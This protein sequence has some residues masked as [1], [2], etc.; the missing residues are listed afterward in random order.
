MSKADAILVIDDVTDRREHTTGQLRA[1]G[2]HHVKAITR[3]R[4]LAELHEQMPGVVFL[5]LNGPLSEDSALLKAIRGEPQFD[6]TAVV[7]GLESFD[8]HDVARALTL[9]ADDCVCRP[10]SWPNLVARLRSQL[11][12][13]RYI[14]RIA[15]NEHDLR[16]VVQLTQALASSSDIRD[17]LFTVAGRIAEITQIDR[18][19]VVL[20]EEGSDVGYVVASSDDE[21]LRDRPIGLNSYPEIREVLTSR[22]PL[23]IEDIEQSELLAKVR[24]NL[25]LAFRS[26]T[27]VPILYQG[28]PLG[29]LFL[30]GKR[31]GAFVGER[32]AM[33]HALANAIAIAIRN[34]RVLQSLRSASEHDVQARQ[35][36]E[37]RMKMLQRYADFFESAADGMVVADRGGHILY[38]NP[39]ASRLMGV[40]RESPSIARIQD[41]LGASETHQVEQLVEGFRAGVYPQGVD[42]QVR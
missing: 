30:R 18:C 35:Q 9:G 13:R 6:T 19:S 22:V 12:A 41:L 29:V 33:V 38:A 32:M 39:M 11:H 1:V 14:A 10:F 26:L 2:L 25:G 27:L 24:D 17:I 15:R 28:D 36:A 37:R 5:E 21:S 3:D 8:D 16:T 42:V 23:V 4:A 20:T 31:P 40:N 34:A 7:I